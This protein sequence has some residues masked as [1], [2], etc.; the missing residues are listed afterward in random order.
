MNYINQM[1]YMSQKFVFKYRFQNIDRAF[2]T[3]QKSK[4]DLKRSRGQS[5]FP[6]SPQVVMGP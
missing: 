5:G 1:N 6:I 3:E 4:L 2:R